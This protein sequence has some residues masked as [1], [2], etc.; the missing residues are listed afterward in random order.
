MST[1]FGIHPVQLKPGVDVAEFER[2]VREEVYPATAR[3]DVTYYVLRGDRGTRSGKYLMIVEMTNVA[4]RDQYWPA[5]GE[6]SA[7]GED[8][9]GSWGEKWF[10]FVSKEEEFTDYVVLGSGP[11]P[12]V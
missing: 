10:T 4:T 5:A 3:P 7:A 8:L 6:L 11:S 2:F 1:V 12:G 9:I